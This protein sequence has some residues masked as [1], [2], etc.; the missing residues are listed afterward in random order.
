MGF[1]FG[2]T[3]IIARRYQISVFLNLFIAREVT[4]KRYFLF[5]LLMISLG[6]S[7]CSQPKAEAEVEPD[8]D[9]MVLLE[10]PD[11]WMSDE[12][13]DRKVVI[14]DCPDPQELL[15]IEA[16]PPQ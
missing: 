4:M 8:Y 12:E 14:T 7:A 9:N 3:L 11:E 5:F 15:I 6:F 1:K 13:K 16:T 10:E 2:P